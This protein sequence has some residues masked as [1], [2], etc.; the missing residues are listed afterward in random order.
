MRRPSSEAACGLSASL[1]PSRAPSLPLLLN[2]S[3][4]G[5]VLDVLIE[6]TDEKDETGRE[7]DLLPVP[8]RGSNPGPL[9][10]EG[11]YLLSFSPSFIFF[12]NS[13]YENIIERPYRLISANLSLISYLSRDMSPSFRVYNP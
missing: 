8:P 1:A 10:R 3:V 5:V 11:W 12:T 7:C 9:S 4:G 2:Q 13:F 6:K